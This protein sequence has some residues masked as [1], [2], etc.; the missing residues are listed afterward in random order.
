MFLGG[1]G[2]GGRGGKRRGPG[3]APVSCSDHV[4][5]KCAEIQNMH[6]EEFRLFC[7]QHELM[8]SLCPWSG[9]NGQLP[10]TRHARLFV[11]TCLPEDC[12]QHLLVGGVVHLTF[13]CHSLCPAQAADSEFHCDWHVSTFSM[14][15][16]GRDLLLLRLAV[17]IFPR[18]CQEPPRELVLACFQKSSFSVRLT[19]VLHK[20]MGP[21]VVR[22]VRLP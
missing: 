2:R 13:L 14:Q 22:L 7:V 4:Q 20:R 9:L 15:L 6:K 17:P 3:S 1:W 21:K 16:F 11:Q 10:F 8:S 18:H 5:I 19:F 12:R